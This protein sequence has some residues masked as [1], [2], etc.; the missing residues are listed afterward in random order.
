[1]RLSVSLAIGLALLVSSAETK[2][3]RVAIMGWPPGMGNPYA[4]QIQGS[5]HP[6]IGL[7]DALTFMDTNGAIL[8]SLAL[9]WTND[10][11]KTWTFKLRTDVSFSNGEPFN[12][13]AVVAMIEWLKL[14]DSAR[15]LFAAEVKNIASVHAVGEDTVVFTTVQ[16]DVILPK[17]LSLLQLVPPALWKQMG[18]DAFSQQPRGTGAFV[19][20]S[21]GRDKGYFMLEAKSGAWRPSKNI[22]RIEYRVLL[23]QAARVQALK[24]G[25][26]DISYNIGFEDFDD[27]KADGFNVVVKPVATTTALA[28]S[29]MRKDSP[30]A[31]KRVRQAINTAVDRAA[32]AATIMRSTFKPT[33]HGIEPGVF[34]YNP[35]IVSYPYEPAKA[36]ALL[37]DAGYAKG[38]KLKASVLSAG[39]PDMAT[40]YQKVAQ[41]LAAVGITLELNSVQGTEW[42][43]MWASGD[44]R[45]ADVLSSSWNGATYMDAGRAVEAYT[46]A[47]PGPFFCAP[48]V[49]KIFAQS[50]VEFD[51]KKREAQLQQALAV[52]HDLAPALYLFPQAEILAAS[53]K[54]KNI[55]YRGRY[56]D[57][58]QIDIT[59]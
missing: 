7:Y 48:E 23:D 12:A 27:L 37:A 26:V 28:L 32:I 40:I 8:P 51:E 46:C 43:Q 17:R 59:P 38:L 45:G 39:A 20:D 44:W 6:F 15:A 42:V 50:N 13:A 25:K 33:S 58:T 36:R 19:V 21:W 41:D 54:V 4:Q 57:L 55:V 14:P 56:V 24:T 3:L 35:A 31:D 49:E 52:L 29:N 2:T 1:M 9:S 53:P 34:G 47:K 22:D 10:G 30:V 16:P 18:A 5:V 11:A